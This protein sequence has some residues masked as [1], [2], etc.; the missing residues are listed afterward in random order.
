MTTALLEIPPP[1]LL[2][3]HRAATIEHLDTDKGTMLCRAAPYDV[4]V[5]L[6]REL[7]ESFAPACFERASNAP[8]RCKLWMGHGGPLVGHATEVEDRPDGVWLNYR[9]SN[10]VNAQEA[11][12]LA[13]DGTLDQV[14]V[15]FRPMRDHMV[16]ERRNDGLHV[17]H[18]RAGLL[19]AALVPHG[20]YDEHAFV[21]S[22]RSDDRASR[23]REARLAR[24]QSLTH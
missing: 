7:F 18:S 15:T 11:R 21:A 1:L 20:A 14:S 19:G 23:E 24:L 10:T 8:T 16:V 4:E 2:E 3:Q 17:R 13:H 22:V 6:D 9:F 12:E 5:A